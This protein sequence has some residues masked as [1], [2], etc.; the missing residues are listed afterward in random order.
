MKTA[1]S[2]LKEL[3][4]FQLQQTSFVDCKSEHVANL[5]QDVPRCQELYQNLVEAVNRTPES[6]AEAT[7]K[8]EEGENGQSI[9]ISK[10]GELTNCTP[11]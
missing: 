8:L 3:Q 5:R 9:S 4:E 6:L 7:S 1:V 10:S 2:K 11:L